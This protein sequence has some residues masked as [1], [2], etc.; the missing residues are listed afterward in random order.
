MT[1]SDAI[2]FETHNAKH[3]DK[4]SN[5]AWNT[6]HSYLILYQQAF[7]NLRFDNNTQNMRNEYWSTILNANRAFIDQNLK[8]I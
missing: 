1:N 4:P 8:R 6:N 5:N 2:C 7:D 3:Y